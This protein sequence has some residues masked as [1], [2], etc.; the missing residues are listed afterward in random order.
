MGQ[1]WI[2]RASRQSRLPQDS[3]QEAPIAPGPPLLLCLAVLNPSTGR[4]DLF[5]P[6]SLTFGQTAAVYAFMK[7]SRAFGM[8]ASKLL[9]IITI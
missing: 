4:P 3:V 9:R 1:W 6:R 5:V 8:I 2:H 7:L